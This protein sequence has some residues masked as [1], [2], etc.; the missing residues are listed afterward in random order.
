MAMSGFIFLSSI[1]DTSTCPVQMSIGVV[2]ITAILLRVNDDGTRSDCGEHTS[3]VHSH[4]IQGSTTSNAT[5]ED[6]SDC[7]SW[8][9]APE[10][11]IR[12]IGFWG[13]NKLHKYDRLNKYFANILFLCNNVAIIIHKYVGEIF[14]GEI[15][16]SHNNCGRE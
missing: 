1:S 5:L 10:Y 2:I 14:I 16:I 11:V 7:S 8:T 12:G 4:I 6:A 15:C 9:A 13:A 3:L